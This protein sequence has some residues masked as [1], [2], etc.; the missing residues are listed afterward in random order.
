MGITI[1]VF[2]YAVGIRLSDKHLV[3]NLAR[4]FETVFYPAFNI[5]MCIWLLPVASHF[6]YIVFLFLPPMMS[7]LVPLVQ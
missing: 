2:F 6:S 5:S 7:T 3:F 1:I 4:I